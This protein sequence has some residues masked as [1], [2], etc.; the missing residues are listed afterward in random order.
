M[1]IGILD[2]IETKNKTYVGV[3]DFIQKKCVHFYDTKSHVT[4]DMVHF[5]VTWRLLSPEVRFSIYLDLYGGS[6]K[7]S[8]RLVVIPRN[9]MK[10]KNMEETKLKKKT[11]KF[12]ALEPD[13]SVD[14][15]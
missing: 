10:N 3:I 7:D 1:T 8:F 11:R 5:I 4:P 2:N 13:P 15:V 12:F 6:L 9:I 14:Q